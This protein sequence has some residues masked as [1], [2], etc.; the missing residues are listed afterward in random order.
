MNRNKKLILAFCCVMPSVPFHPVHAQ[1]SPGGRPAIEQS[2]T[3]PFLDVENRIKN[4]SVPVLYYISKSSSPQFDLTEREFSFL[5]RNDM[6]N[7]ALDV[8][9]LGNIK[10]MLNVGHIEKLALIIE[11][12]DGRNS[13]ELALEYEREYFS[14]YKKYPTQFISVDV[15]SVEKRILSRGV[16]R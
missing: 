15:D 12:A 9:Y 8:Y 11:R 14:E 6:V 4:S 10:M 13:R 7:F 5:S 2:A 1:E 16:I 3:T